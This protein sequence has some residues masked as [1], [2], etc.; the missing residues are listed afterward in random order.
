VFILGEGGNDRQSLEYT[1]DRRSGEESAEFTELGRFMSTSV[2][3]EG[4]RL[5]TSISSSGSVDVFDITRRLRRVSAEPVVLRYD[6]Q[7]K[8]VARESLS[9]TQKIDM[10]EAWRV[11]TTYMLRTQPFEASPADDV[12]SWLNADYKKLFGVDWNVASVPMR[13]PRK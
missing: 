13:K 4:T 9:L 7:V 8:G 1:S 3:E 2:N 6:R 5:E 11:L 12:K 10:Q